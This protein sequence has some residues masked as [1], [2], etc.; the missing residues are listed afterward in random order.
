MT[1][2]TGS[3]TLEESRAFVEVYPIEPTA[4]G[5]LDGLTF[6]VKDIIDVA[7]R[8]TGCGNPSWR[9]SHAPA[10]SNA[11]C[12][13]QLLGAGARGIGKTAT[14]ELA[15]SLL[16]ENHFSGTPLNPRAPDRVP[17]GS[18]SGSASAVACG[19]VD[20][21]LGTDTGGSVRV[22]ASNCGLFGIR[23][24]HGFI[25]L[26]G[27]MPFAPGFDTV[28]VLARDAD[29]LARAAGV[30]LGADV[31]ARPKVGTIHM[32]CEAFALADPAVVTA[33]EGALTQLRRLS[34]SRV[35][36]TSIHAIDGEPDG[37]SLSVWY[38]K[39]FRPLQWS[40]IWSNLSGWISSAQPTFGPVT[41]HNFEMVRK[42]DRGLLAET[43]RR[44]ERYFQ[45]LMAFLGPED[46]L[47]IP[48]VPTPAPIKGTVGR[49]DQDTTDYYPRALPLTSLAGVGRL[50]QVSL[51][52]GNIGGVPVGLSLVGRFGQDAFLLGV[53][54]RITERT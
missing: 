41:G 8:R 48:T 53:V 31:P 29:V 33:L 38:E 1:P 28:G 21:A 18:S 35:V 32:I 5:P 42:L 9:E 10:V 3:I 26:A 17:G 54:G 6:A 45:R 46:L 52:L 4:P 39:A 51:P 16:G 47:C 25:S 37:T 11:V 30:L 40:E 7:G 15:F 14:D 27:V 13:D 50:P 22:P 36:E 12:V 43:V 24:S 34:G 2:P 23:P 44:R 20:F 49:R 19:L